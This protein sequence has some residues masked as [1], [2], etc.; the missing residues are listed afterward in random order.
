V[1]GHDARRLELPVAELR[2]LMEVVSE[3][4]DLGG[5]SFNRRVDPGV[6]GCGECG[7]RENECGAERIESRHGTLLFWSDLLDVEA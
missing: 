7:E 5:I 6:L 2:V 1:R 4:D 3:L